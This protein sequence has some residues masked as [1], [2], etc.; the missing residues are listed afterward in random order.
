MEVNERIAKL[1]EA[2][3][4][5]FNEHKHFVEKLTRVQAEVNE[6]Y[7]RLET[8]IDN[9]S[10]NDFREFKEEIEKLLS[11]YVTV[12]EFRPVKNIIYGMVGFILLAFIG[13]IATIIIK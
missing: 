3:E 10:K 7:I 1:E 13:S 11:N 9:F 5:S 12:Q 6:K 4:Y 2:K 8:K